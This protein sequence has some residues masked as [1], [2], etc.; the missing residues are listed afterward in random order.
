MLTMEREEIPLRDR[1]TD[2]YS[3]W[4]SGSLI[5][6]PLKTEFLFVPHIILYAYCRP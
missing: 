4:I 5:A 1:G 6:R 3:V 2:N